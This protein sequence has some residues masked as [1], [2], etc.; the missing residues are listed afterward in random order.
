MY[1]VAGQRGQG[2]PDIR[3]KRAGCPRQ[4]D[5]EGRV[6]RVAGQRGQGVPDSRAKRAGCIE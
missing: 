3:A 6:C 1:R 4:Q 2:V 5:K